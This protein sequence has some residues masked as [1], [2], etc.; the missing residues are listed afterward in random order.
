MRMEDGYLM[1]ILCLLGTYT[2]GFFAQTIPNGL[3]TMEKD[4]QNNPTLQAIGVDAHVGFESEFDRLS[5]E[6]AEGGSRA[7]SDIHS[8]SHDEPDSQS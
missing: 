2:W 1:A 5:E 4:D 3:D 6:R 8:A 7:A